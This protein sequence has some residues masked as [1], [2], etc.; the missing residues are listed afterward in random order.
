MT[1]VFEKI[2]FEVTWQDWR[3]GRNR[4]CIR[5]PVA[6]ALRRVK[7][8]TYIAVQLETVWIRPKMYRLD[9]LTVE[10]IEKFDHTYFP[11]EASAVGII[12]P[13]RGIAQRLV[14][15]SMQRREFVMLAHSFE[16]LKHKCEGSFWS[17]K[18][19][20]NR[21]LWLPMTR[22]MDFQKV[23]FANTNR[24]DRNHVCSGLWSRS[25][26]PIF[27]PD[28]FLDKLPIGH[29]LDGELFT[30]RGGFQTTASYI[31]KHKPID[32]EW[33]RV[34]YYV[35]DIP[36]YVRVFEPGRINTPNFAE[37]L[38]PGNLALEMGITVDHPWNAPRRFEQVWNYLRT[39]WTPAQ[40]G[41]LNGE[42]APLQQTQLPMNR[43]KA[44]AELEEQMRLIQ[45][46]G[47]EGIMLRRPH[48]LWQPKRTDEI[49]KVKRMHDMEGVVIGYNYGMG[50]LYGLVG[51]IRLRCQKPA[52][53][54]EEKVIVPPVFEFDL[55]GFTDLERT[56]SPEYRLEA[57]LNPGQYI[58]HA[59]I[60]ERFPLGTK[61]TFQYRELTDGGVPKE[62]RY[63]RPRPTGV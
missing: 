40:P 13:H 17:E 6:L 49:L 39:N 18:L 19:D 50:K 51:S 61:I 58:N 30:T 45:E 3:C 21:C 2:E 55:S 16:P 46:Y 28:W 44:E 47:G 53:V 32:E 31:K 24:D 14:E 60:S 20:G 34:G 7:P 8:D 26:K 29:A 63:L 25:G 52:D 15:V 59:S 48:S 36:G 1:P 35:Y 22:G 62:A 43:F 4:D 57:Q 38:I 33:R 5:C 54:H 42:W 10:L 41:T 11:V 9:P 37:K 23:V 27:A 56:I 12:L